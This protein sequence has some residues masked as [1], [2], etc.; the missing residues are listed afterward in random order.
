VR[1]A[2]LYARVLQCYPSDYRARFTQEML[3]VFEQA[4]A[5]RAPQRA[6]TF[7]A[8]ELW[9][10]VGAIGAEWVAKLTTDVAARGR[11]L[12]DCRLMRPAG[13]SKREWAAGLA[14]IDGE[15]H[16]G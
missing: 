7:A 11:V 16:A 14:S 6:F 9:A 15:R 5:A 4:A 2:R 8:S 13:V 12:P 1:A 3:S 10:L